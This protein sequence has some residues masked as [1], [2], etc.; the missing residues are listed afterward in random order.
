MFGKKRLTSIIRKF[1]TYQEIKGTVIP[2]CVSDLRCICG[3]S[4]LYVFF[5]YFINN[6]RV[7]RMKGKKEVN[8]FNIDEIY[9]DLSK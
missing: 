9:I 6:I 1:K 7:K 2:F 8:T 5:S 4:F 3:W